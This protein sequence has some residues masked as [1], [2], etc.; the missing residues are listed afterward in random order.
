MQDDPHAKHKNM[1]NAA[2]DG[3]RR[4]RIRSPPRSFFTIILQKHLILSNK[5]GIINR[6]SGCSA[7]GSA[8]GSGPRGR[9]FKSRHSDH[10]PGFLPRFF[11]VGNSSSRA[12]TGFHRV[13]KIHLTRRVYAATQPPA[14]AGVCVGTKTGRVFTDSVKERLRLHPL[15]RT[16]INTN[17]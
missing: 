4:F 3:T 8:L 11:Y 10:R 13:F 9:G 1:P 5:S 7:D 12:E 17:C 16:T 14:H 6:P 2:T 15:E